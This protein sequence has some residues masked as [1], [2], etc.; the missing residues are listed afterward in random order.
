M[1]ALPGLSGA[2]S[3][4]AWAVSAD[5]SIIVGQSTPQGPNSLIAFIWDAVHGTRSLKTV[6]ED[7]HGLDLTGWQLEFAGGISADGRTIVGYGINPSG[8]REAWI[9]TIPEP[10]S[11]ALLALGLGLLASR[12]RLASIG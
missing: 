4:S 11:A 5:G 6:L 9:A 8:Q 1:V 7:D 2:I 10:G 12:R 3:D